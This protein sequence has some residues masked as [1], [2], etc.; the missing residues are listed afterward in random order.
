MRAPWGEVP[1]GEAVWGFAN[2]TLV[3][4]WDL[5]VATGQPAEAPPTLVEPVLARAH[6]LVPAGARNPRAYAPAVGAGRGAGP[7]ERLASW[8][9]HRWPRW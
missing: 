8:H 6:A 5:A 7:T 3:H 9:G 2:E 4:G 1:A